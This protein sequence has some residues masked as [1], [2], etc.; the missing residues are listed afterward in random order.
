MSEYTLW[1]II[2]GYHC[3]TFVKILST[4]YITKLKEEIKKEATPFLDKFLA[5]GLVLWKVHYF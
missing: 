4:Q 5:M 3:L 1:H 2:E